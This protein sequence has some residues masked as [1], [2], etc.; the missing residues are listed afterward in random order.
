M[1]ADA[2]LES[3]IVI[4]IPAHYS[5]GTFLRPSTTGYYHMGAPKTMEQAEP[6]T[7]MFALKH[8]KISLSPLHLLDHTT[9]RGTEMENLLEATKNHL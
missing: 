6:G 5:Y 9:L 1:R 4:T 8:G 3:E 7:D 2:N